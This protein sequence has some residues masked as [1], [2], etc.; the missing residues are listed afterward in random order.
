MAA[1]VA[2]GIIGWL[3]SVVPLVAVN[4]LDNAGV[5][6]FPDPVLVAAVALVGGLLLGGVVAGW[7]GGRGRQG[8]GGPLAAGTIAGGLFAVSLITLLFVARSLYD[9]PTVLAEH[10]LRASAAVLFCAALLLL[11]ALLAGAVTGRRAAAVASV[12]PARSAPVT[13][14]ARQRAAGVSGPR[15]PWAD[16]PYPRDGRAAPNS[17]PAPRYAQDPRDTP[18]PPSGWPVSPPSGPRS[19]PAD[20]PRVRGPRPW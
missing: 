17:V 19:R 8:S 2:G 11:V 7:A 9:L 18:A 4:V 5:Y 1:R 20:A 16:A 3:V 10:P 14:A 6:Y 13:S 12:A 15:G